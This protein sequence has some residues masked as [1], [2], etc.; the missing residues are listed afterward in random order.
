MKLICEVKAMVYGIVDKEI[1]SKDSKDNVKYYQAHVRQGKD[2]AT[3][4]ISADAVIQ[5][6]KELM[7]EQY[8]QCEYDTERGKLRIL[9]IVANPFNNK[10]TLTNAPK[11]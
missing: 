11:A 3:V 4:S 10:P 2:M 7:K 5:V 1:E 6:E 8:L 9:G